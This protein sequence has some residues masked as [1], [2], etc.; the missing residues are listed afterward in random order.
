MI[1]KRKNKTN[2]KQNNL[3]MKE[4]NFFKEFFH[5]C[6]YLPDF[7]GEIPPKTNTSNGQFSNCPTTSSTP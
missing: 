4:F 6:Y 1:L 3:E 2:K 5:C 7:L